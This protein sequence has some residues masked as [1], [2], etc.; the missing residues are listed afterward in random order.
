M[1]MIMCIRIDIVCPNEASRYAAALRPMDNCKCSGPKDV[2]QQRSPGPSNTTHCLVC[3]SD[4]PLNSINL[5]PD[6]GTILTDS[7]AP[8]PLYPLTSSANSQQ[9][10]PTP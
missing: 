7:R 5:I 1:Y 8:S 3:V 4:N 6:M 2:Q 10:T 9:S